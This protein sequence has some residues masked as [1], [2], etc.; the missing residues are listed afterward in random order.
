VGLKLDKLEDKAAVLGGGG[1]SGVGLDAQRLFTRKLCGQL[2]SIQH[3]LPA[4]L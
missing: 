2:E 1:I 4:L 3:E